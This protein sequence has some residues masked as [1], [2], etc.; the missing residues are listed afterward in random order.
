MVTLDK[1]KPLRFVDPDNDDHITSVEPISAE[2]RSVPPFVILKGAHILHKWDVNDLP[3]D[4]VLAVSSA[5]YS[6][7]RLAYDWLLHVTLFRAQ[8]REANG[9]QWQV[10]LSERVTYY[11]QIFDVLVQHHPE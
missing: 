2:A 6:N 4:I 1:S 9:E 3:N 10:A 5:G 8:I 11:G 7:D